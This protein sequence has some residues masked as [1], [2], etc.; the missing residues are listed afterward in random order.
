MAIFLGYQ[1]AVI[2]WRLPRVRNHLAFTS[3]HSL[4]ISMGITSTQLEVE[5][6]H[7]MT[8]ALSYL[9]NPWDVVVSSPNL[10][11]RSGRSRSHVRSR[12]LP[13]RSGRKLDDGV[14]LVSPELCLLQMSEQLELPKLIELID[15][16][17]GGYALPVDGTA[18]SPEDV[19]PL[20]SIPALIDYVDASVGTP[21]CRALRRA[22]RYAVENSGSPMETIVELLLCLPQSMGGYGLPVPT[23]NRRVNIPDELR[24][25][26]DKSFYVCDLCW[27]NVGGKK[28]RH[29]LDVEYES[30]QWHTGPG[31]LAQ[32]SQR[33]NALEALGAHVITVTS[34]EVHSTERF[35]RVA[36]L[37]AQELGIR[38]RTTLSKED[39]A[40]RR[41]KLR[42]ALLDRDC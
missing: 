21:G 35:D 6:S 13:A 22:L 40:A 1:S 24:R 20:T 31:R 17:C 10:R 29:L 41:D 14:Y 16:F 11:D 25:P 5:V 36:R 12:P 4:E 3:T 9:P 23:M 42:R 33:R 8:D 39:L 32:D 18:Q 19:S 15:E 38:L 26:N 7:I 2:L 30:T 28:R 27:P 37:I 34:A